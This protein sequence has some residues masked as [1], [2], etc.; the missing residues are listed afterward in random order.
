MRSTSKSWLRTHDT[1]M[2]VPD[3]FICYKDFDAQMQYILE[4]HNHTEDTLAKISNLF[5][6]AWHRVRH[7]IY[8]QIHLPLQLFFLDACSAATAI[9]LSGASETEFYSCV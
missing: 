9:T 5:E 3:G 6:S 8:L 1:V 7:Q 4:S 2:F